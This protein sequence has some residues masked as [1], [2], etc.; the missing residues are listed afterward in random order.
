[1]KKR[2]AQAVIYYCA[3]DKIKHFLLL[4]MNKKRNGFWQN[5]TGSVEENESFQDGAIRE[6]IEETNLSSDN[7]KEV[8]NLG[9]K[10]TFL[11]QWGRNIEEE[12]FSIEAKSEW[13]IKLDPSEHQSYKWVQEKEI[14]R[15]SVHFESNYKALISTSKKC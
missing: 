2:K 8:V 12:V 6:A 5:V 9:L 1:M 14:E 10:F 15:S 4:R 11:D 13:T 3:Q 7:I